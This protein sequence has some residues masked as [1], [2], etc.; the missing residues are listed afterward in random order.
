MDVLYEFE[1]ISNIKVG[2]FVLDNAASNDS[3][4]EEIGRKL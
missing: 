4:V 3:V 2:C 1:L